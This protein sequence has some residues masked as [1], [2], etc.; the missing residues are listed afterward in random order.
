MK[1]AM[2]LL[3]NKWLDKSRE[4]CWMPGFW[5]KLKNFFEIICLKKDFW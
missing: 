1:K 2:G 3:L 4:N 5:K